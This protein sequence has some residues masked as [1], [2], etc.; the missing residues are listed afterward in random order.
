MDKIKVIVCDDEIT[1]CQYYQNILESTEDIE[2]AGSAINVTDCIELIKNTMPDVLLLDLQIGYQ[3]AGFKVLGEVKKISRKTKVIML[4][5]YDTESNFFASIENG[6]DYFLGKTTSSDDIVSAIRR[7]YSAEE[8]YDDYITER[9]LSYSTDLSKKNDSLMYLI[10]ILSKLTKS[11]VEILRDLC[12]GF[13]YKQIAKKR[14]VTENTVRS[15]VT[16][17][18]F[19]LGYKDIKDL[20]KIAKELGIFTLYN[21]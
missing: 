1:I 12:N 15:Q 13:N 6:A 8:K 3:E 11:E 14:F 5:M 19:K 16:R 20:V 4:T 18:S 10:A 9:L 2:F 7:I 17:I 21:G